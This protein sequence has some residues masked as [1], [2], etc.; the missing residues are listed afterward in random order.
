GPADHVDGVPARWVARPATAAEV[1]AVAGHNHRHGLAAVARGSAT[2][3]D[4][5]TPP[6]RM[7]VMVGLG[8]LSRG[9]EH[10]AGELVRE[11]EA[12][13][14]L[15]TVQSQVATHGQQLAIDGP[16]HATV[17]GII[18]TGA[19]GPRRLKY[20]TVRDLLIGITFARADGTLASAGG[21]VVKNVAG[22]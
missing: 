1:A 18:A 8:R 19:S 10:S 22:Y 4:W 11:V 14:Q 17:G 7:D 20:G 2:K 6:G 3:L 21:K 12:G 16:P 13:C 5:G 9:I 15:S